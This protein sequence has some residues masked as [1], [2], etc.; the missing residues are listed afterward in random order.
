MNT[1]YK[2]NSENEYQL[3]CQNKINGIYYSNIAMNNEK[4]KEHV[5]D[6]SRTLHCSEGEHL[7]KPE[8]LVFVIYYSK[9]MYDDWSDATIPFTYNG[10]LNE[11]IAEITEKQ[12]IFVKG[13]PK[14]WDSIDYQK[15]GA[16]ELELESKCTVVGVN[17]EFNASVLY[18]VYE[19][20]KKAYFKVQRLEEWIAESHHV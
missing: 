13:Y 20:N 1:N 19:D 12:D 7:V 15:R 8:P 16:K 10:T 5:Q 9:G 4:I 11:L 18:D 6:I 3:W 2:F 14:I 17:C